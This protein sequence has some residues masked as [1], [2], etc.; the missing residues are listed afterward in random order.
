MPSVCLITPGQPSTNP[1]LV[2]EA[3]ALSEAGYNVSV[4]CAHW[5][6]WADETDR[7]LLNSRVWGKSVRYVGG[8]PDARDGRYLLS[9]ARHGFSN[10]L[11]RVAGLDKQLQSWSLCRVLPELTRAAKET[12]ADL[13]IGHNLGALPPAVIAAR[14][15]NAKVGFDAEDFHSG[16]NPTNGAA[17]DSSERVEREFLPHCDYLTAASPDI[18]RAYAEKYQLP[19]PLS[20]LNVF[21]LAHRPGEITTSNPSAPLRLYWFSQTIGR[22]RGLEDVVRAIGILRLPIELHIRGRWHPDFRQELFALA[23]SCG[24]SSAQIISHEPALSDDMVR[25]AAE[26]DIGLALEPSHTLNNDLCI[27]NKIFT[28]LLAGCGII[29]TSTRGQTQVLEQTGKAG[30]LYHPGDSEALAAAIRYWYEDRNE[31]GRARLDAW[32]WGETKFNWDVEKRKF[33]DVVESTLGDVRYALA[34][35]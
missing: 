19:A 24:V 28:Y 29:A 35:R 2:K 18:A 34:C 32:Y 6:D 3:D 1:R 12:V 30:V 20:I 25:L 31:L 27:S 21:P 13:Y 16:I 26:F 17:V 8:A 22:N 5:A 4:I 7:V 33:L 15:N 9:R 14:S 11:S 23:R 10:R